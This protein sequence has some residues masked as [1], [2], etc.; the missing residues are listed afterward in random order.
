MI[1]SAFASTRPAPV[2]SSHP[3]AWGW[4][5][6]LSVVTAC[7][8]LAIAIADT[9]ARNRDSWA[10]PLFWAGL[11][12]L[13]I[14]VAA[15]LIS[16][17]ASRHERISLV[18]LLGIA[19]YLVKVLY[20]PKIF[21]LM[22]ES[23]HWR[24]LSDITRGGYLFRPNPLLPVSALYPGLETVTAALA[25]LGGL[26]S[27]VAAKIVVGTGRILIVLA[28]FLLYE[29]ASGSSRTAGIA[30]LLYAA[31]PGFLL[32]DSQFAYESLALPMAALAL[33]L[34][35]RRTVSPARSLLGLTVAAL[36]VL[37]DVVLTHHV[38]SYMLA[39]FLSLW[40]AVTIG[41][42]LRGDATHLGPGGPA[43]LLVVGALSW[44][45]YVASLTIG[46][47]SP[48]I[49]G[50][51]AELIRLIGGEVSS[52]QLFRNY[53]GSVAP[54]W[55]RVMAFASVLL[56]LL[57]LPFGLWQLWR[58]HR[59][60]T[61][62]LAL[63]VAALAYPASLAARFTVYGAE[64]AN[65]SSEFI[66]VALAFVVAVGS[67]EFGLA[68]SRQWGVRPLLFLVGA[69]V[70]FTGGVI[71]GNPA[72]ARMPGPYLVGADTRSIDRQGIETAEWTRAFLGPGNRIVSDRTNE[73][74]LGT[75]G[76]QRPVT[77]YGDREPA[78][79]VFLA[80]EVGPNEWAVV[81]HAQ[82]RY[83]VVD[84]RMSTALPLI[85]VYYEVGEP[86][87][88]HRTTPIDAGA[89]AKFDYVPEL[90]R[91]YDSGAIVI[92]DAG[93]LRSGEGS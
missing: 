17:G 61:L 55:E 41:Q 1:A 66:F 72:W 50:A 91:L 57:G 13:F 79:L 59:A 70:I 23:A 15:R 21:T 3:V 26:S 69:T 58:K 28:L 92:Y 6:A 90:S 10:Y 11:L 29:Q 19:L 65:R 14:P 81:R 45:I 32:F 36:L 38:T 54:P 74:L 33:F 89:L 34:I 73:T 16:S 88:Y 93:R 35:A 5:P 78:Y 39:A 68:A 37:G 87:T 27:F 64:A 44:L 84:E 85:G 30:V 20:S 76:Y 18:L 43:L 63:A 12:A 46:Y 51:V 86:G 25:S 53:T 80:N 31:N 42:R 77:A 60:R 75:Y 49:Q 52:R 24:T 67:V 22:D 7:G 83:I 2:A 56:L 8:L 47:L 9:G 40:G 4:V 82:V 48:Q 71:V 62:A